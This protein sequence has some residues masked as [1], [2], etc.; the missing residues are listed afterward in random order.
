MGDNDPLESLTNMCTLI[1][2]ILTFTT[3]NK[4]NS[5]QKLRKLLKNFQTNGRHTR[6][7]N[8]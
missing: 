8:C 5:S 7:R 4:F 6:S 2:K 1:Y 3:I